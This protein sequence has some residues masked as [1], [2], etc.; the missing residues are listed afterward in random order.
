[1]VLG[2][3]VGIVVVAPLVIGLGQL[4]R[5]R[6][7]KSELIESM[8]ALSLLTLVS[9]YFVSCPT[10]SWVSFCLGAFVLPRCCGW[11]RAAAGARCRSIFVYVGTF[12]VS[13][14]VIWA[15][16]FGIGHFGDAAIPGADRAKGAQ[17]AVLMVTVYTLV[18][19]ALLT[20]RRSSEKRLHR[21]L[22]ALPAAIQTTDPAGRITYCNQ[23]A[24]EC[25]GNAR[26]SAKTR[27]ISS[28]GSTILTADR[29]RIMS[30]R[31]RSR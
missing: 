21:L 16:T 31:A 2:D 19:S 24:V 26:S 4:W 30:S 8:A 22:D 17:A 29:C 10:S 12:V 6:L 23:A 3:G 5:E 13:G 18:L 27:G 1:M 28:I 14:I 20:E 25:G 11:R 7:S 9:L 15:T